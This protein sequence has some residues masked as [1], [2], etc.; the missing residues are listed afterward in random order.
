[1][2]TLTN[3]HGYASAAEM[4]LLIPLARHIQLV[5]L[6]E[7]IQQQPNADPAFWESYF[8]EADVILVE[9]LAAIDA[10]Q[11][12]PPAIHELVKNK[13]ADIK[14]IFD[15][16]APNDFA[17]SRKLQHKK[18][19]RDP[20]RMRIAPFVTSFSI[21]PPHKQ[22]LVVQETAYR[23]ALHFQSEPPWKE[24]PLRTQLGGCYKYRVIWPDSETREERIC[25]EAS[26]QHF[27]ITR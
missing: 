11:L 15:E 27:Q 16:R 7:Y 1:L 4:P 22:F 6:R 19:H 24:I 2:P 23:L 12:E 5:A 10:R 25:I 9:C 26:G 20:G 13:D 18:Y 21:S 8:K 14:K 3:P 17:Q